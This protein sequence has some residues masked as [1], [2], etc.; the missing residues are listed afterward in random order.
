MDEQ[1]P[2]NNGALTDGKDEKGR[3]VKGNDFGQGRPKG[4]YSLTTII[5]KLL[6]DEQVTLEDGKKINAGEALTRKV[7]KQALEGDTQSL[8]LIFNYVEGM[9]VQKNEISTP[10]GIRIEVEYVNDRKDKDAADGS[11]PAGEG[12]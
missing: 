7:L 5:K 9:P 10:E 12:V 1:K 2:I 6:Q 8:K 4:T 3:F 11:L